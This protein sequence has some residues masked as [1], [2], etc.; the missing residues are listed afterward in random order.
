MLRTRIVLAAAA[1]ALVSCDCRGDDSG[2]VLPEIVPLQVGYT[3]TFEK[4]VTDRTG[5]ITDK[6]TDRALVKEAREIDGTTWFR[7][8]EFGDEFWIRNGEGGQF[9]ADLVEKDGKTVIEAKYV[10][11]RYPVE[12]APVTYQTP[13]TTVTL[14]TASRRVVTPAGTFRCHHYTL[15]EP[16]IA[17]EMSVA[18]G[19]GLVWHRY[20]DKKTGEVTVRR[21]VS[22]ETGEQ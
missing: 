21:L 18:P 11:F 5:K 7:Y 1:V 2:G 3:W 22:R 17:S 12:K 8:V 20:T 19:I 10:F 13:H 16:D 4:V 9:E 15:D 6:G 14:H